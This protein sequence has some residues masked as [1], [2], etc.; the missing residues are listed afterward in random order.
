M[1]IFNANSKHFQSADRTIGPV[2]KMFHS[3][4]F[5]FT[6]E[7]TFH[8]NLPIT[9]AYIHIVSTVYTAPLEQGFKSKEKCYIQ[10]SQQTGTIPLLEPLYNMLL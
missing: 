5:S 9:I 7:L 10:P 6:G 4:H 1:I 3:Q 8:N 2:Q